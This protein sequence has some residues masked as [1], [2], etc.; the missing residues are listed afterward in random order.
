MINKAELPRFTW[1][2]VEDVVPANGMELVLMSGIVGFDTQVCSLG[3][4]SPSEGK[5][6]AYN[7]EFPKVPTHWCRIEMPW[8]D[9]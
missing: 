2:R 8:A 6:N 9:E 7:P 4:Y 1:F 3:T 5:W